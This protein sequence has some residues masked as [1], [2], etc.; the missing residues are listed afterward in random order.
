M[1]WRKSGLGWVY[2]E[3]YDKPKFDDSL[4]ERQHHPYE[5]AGS[6]FRLIINKDAAPLSVWHITIT[7]A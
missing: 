3:L 6:K 7:K 4:L 5:H 2:Q 1:L